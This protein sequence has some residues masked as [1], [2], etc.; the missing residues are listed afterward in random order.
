MKRISHRQVTVFWHKE[1]KV[2]IKQFYLFKVKEPHVEILA[3]LIANLF[4]TQI[5]IFKN[6]HFK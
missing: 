3:A 4:E 5:I 6:K 1:H 2:V